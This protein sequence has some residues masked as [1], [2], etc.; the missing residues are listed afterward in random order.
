MLGWKKKI[1][2]DLVLTNIQ[3][4]LEKKYKLKI[5]DSTEKPTQN[6]EN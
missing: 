5:S 1:K 3:Y 6:L 2:V 4:N